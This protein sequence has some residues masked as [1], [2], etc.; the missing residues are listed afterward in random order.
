MITVVRTGNPPNSFTGCGGFFLQEES[1]GT[2]QKRL[3]SQQGGAERGGAEK[4]LF[5]KRAVHIK[6]R[7]VFA[8]ADA[9]YYDPA[10]LGSPAFPVNFSSQLFQSTACRPKTGFYTR[11]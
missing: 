3:N 6:R 4:W 11:Y 7:V 8:L 5:S 2:L 1:G 9:A 10:P